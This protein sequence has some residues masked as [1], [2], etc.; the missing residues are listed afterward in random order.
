MQITP[1]TFEWVSKYQAKNKNWDAADIKSPEINI[2]IGTLF[3]ATLI[4][5]YKNEVLALCAYN[6]GMNALDRWLRENGEFKKTADTE[7]I[8]YPETREY[9]KRVRRAKKMYQKLYFE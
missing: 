3:I 8:P 4:K 7:H 6:A 9:V 1:E 2:K 5:K